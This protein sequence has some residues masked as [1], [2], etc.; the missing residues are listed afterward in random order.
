[1]SFPAVSV[2][3]F[4]LEVNSYNSWEEKL[5]IQILRKSFHSDSQ[6]ALKTV[7]SSSLVNV[8]AAYDGV[9]VKQIGAADLQSQ[10]LIF[11][12]GDK[13]KS[14]LCGSHSFVSGTFHAI[15]ATMP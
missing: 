12:A 11:F 4:S 14:W 9:W 8:K 10:Q 1:M 15:Q 5:S 2:V 13:K 3:C 7:H 6:V